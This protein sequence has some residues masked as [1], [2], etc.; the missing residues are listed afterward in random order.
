MTLHTKKPYKTLD[1]NMAI[2][3]SYVPDELDEQF[4]TG[5]VIVFDP[6]EG[7]A[8]S[9]GLENWNSAGETTEYDV[10][11]IVEPF[12]E[13]D[14]NYNNYMCNAFRKYIK[15]KPAVLSPKREDK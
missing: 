10:N 7:G 15:V 5:F 6:A 1:G 9:V 8:T 14:P 12:L 2:I 3:T 4:Y 11:N 13:N